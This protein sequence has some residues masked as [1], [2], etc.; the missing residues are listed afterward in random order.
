MSAGRPSPSPRA[1]RRARRSTWSTSTSATRCRSVLA[2][3]RKKEAPVKWIEG[4][5]IVVAVV[6]VAGLGAQEKLPPAGDALAELK[7]GNEHHAAK[8]YQ[9]PHQTAARQ[10]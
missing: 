7:A 2:S 1:R 6:L 9:H 8:H 4:T 10:R 5:L 3:E